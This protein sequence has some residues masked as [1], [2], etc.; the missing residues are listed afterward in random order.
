MKS[1]RS[2]G[3]QDRGAALLLAIGFVVA[4]GAISGGLASIA[5]SG[6]NNRVTIETVRDREYAADGAIEI[7]ISDARA[8][9]CA[10]TTGVRP[11]VTINSIAIRVDW[12]SSCATSVRSS[13]GSAYQQ[14]NVAFAACV[15]AGSACG[16]ANVIIRAQ[17]N[18]DPSIGAV[19][20]TYV[21][22]W[23]VTR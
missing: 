17:V 4:I 20:R 10:A 21:Q 5:T 6:L 23:N 22:S 1:R 13:D 15:D 14:R 3:E 19:V 11:T 9:V 8:F 16:D 2:R 7:A 18:F 12:T